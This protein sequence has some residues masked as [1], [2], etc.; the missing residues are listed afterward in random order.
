[1]IQTATDH[2]LTGLMARIIAA[3]ANNDPRLVLADYLEERGDPRGEFIRVQCEM[4]QPEGVRVA[5]GRP[6]HG[7]I[8]SVREI[9]SKRSLALR[10]RERELFNWHNI[11]RWFSHGPWLR[12]Y[13]NQAEFTSCNVFGM[14]VSRGFVE[15]VTCTLA[16]WYVTECHYCQG[17]GDGG[18][19]LI[20]HRC[21]GT[22][23]IDG[24]GPAIVAAQPVQQVTL[25]DRRP[26]VTNTVNRLENPICFSW[27]RATD[28]DA[29]ARLPAPLFN[30]LT[31][32][33]YRKD[34]G[35][36]ASAQA[37]LSHACLAW[38]RKAAGLPPPVIR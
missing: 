9:D 27:F 38:A 35:T 34:Y 36:E 30:A 26:A 2:V 7:Q 22:G 18:P 31:I 16:D 19:S 25:S 6:E 28:F 8:V 17:S 37:A 14:L 13:T 33:A 21:R 15:A 1:M 32:R 12:T 10:R 20:C 23:R 3:P 11:E 5:E 4:A 29:P 24:H